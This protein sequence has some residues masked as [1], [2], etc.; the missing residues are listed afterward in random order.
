MHVYIG[1]ERK[2]PH[3][4]GLGIIWRQLVSFMLQLLYPRGSPNIQTEGWVSPAAGLDVVAKRKFL[5]LLGIE[6]Q[7]FNPISYAQPIQCMN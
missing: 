6:L 2:A 7:L 3:I 1:H 5:P 4:L